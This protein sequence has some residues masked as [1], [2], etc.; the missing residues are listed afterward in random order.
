MRS[1]E[2]ACITTPAAWEVK[3]KGAKSRH[4]SLLSD[5]GCTVLVL[6]DVELADK[7]YDLKPSPS[8]PEHVLMNAHKSPILKRGSID[9]PI[10]CTRTG[11]TRIL[12]SKNCVYCPESSYNISSWS[13]TA[14][15]V[16]A[17]TTR[18]PWLMIGRNEVGMPTVDGGRVWGER[19]GGLYFFN[20]RVTGAE[21]EQALVHY[22]DGDNIAS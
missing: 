5:T 21:K 4:L 15:L 17:Q 2:V 19:V 22:E 9:L 10:L 12:S 14:D 13:A 3:A 11:A 20:L 1:V 16:F 8:T 7:M 18:E 6:G